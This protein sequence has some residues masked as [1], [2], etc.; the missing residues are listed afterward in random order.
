MLEKRIE[1]KR[2]NVKILLLSAAVLLIVLFLL[3]SV[4]RS[5][6]KIKTQEDRLAYIASLGWAIDPGSEEL[7]QVLIPDCGEGFMTE[8]NELMRRG[9]FDLSPFAGK[10]AERCS[11]RLLDYPGC[12]EHVY[13]ILY[14]YRGRVIGG[15]IH[16]AALDGFMHELCAKA[17]VE[18]KL[19]GSRRFD[20]SKKQ[21]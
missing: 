6:G 14:L 10:S 13:L 7:S 8:Y 4:G 3:G 21:P 16:T 1:K 15:D 5:G 11:Y 2:K 19:S 20:D 17:A 18:E 9:G 12:E